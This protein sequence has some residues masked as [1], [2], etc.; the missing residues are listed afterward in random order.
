MALGNPSYYGMTEDERALRGGV[1]WNFQ[2]LPHSERE[3]KTIANLYD[4]PK[5]FAEEEATEENFKIEASQFET[6]HLSAHGLLDE[7]MPMYSGI[8]LTQDEDPV[9]DGFLQAYE[10]FNLRLNA[11]LVTLSGCETGL[12]EIKHGEGLI[13]LTRAFMYAG[14]KSLVVSLWS[15]NDESTCQI[16]EAFYSNMMEKGLSKV[17]ALRQ[18]KLKLMGMEKDLGDG[19]KL[20]YAHPFFWAPFVLVG[21]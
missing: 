7:S 8:V 2:P 11:E 12:G 15:V 18:A 10:I 13:G 9:E 6:I 3:V 16:M 17:E 1:G 19:V 14:A 21:D 20:S 5:Y 4:R